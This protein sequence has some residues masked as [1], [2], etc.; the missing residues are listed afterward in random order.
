[1]LR[2]REA[3]INAPS[4]LKTPRVGKTAPTGRAAV[5]LQP[6]VVL[7][8]RRMGRK[9]IGSLKKAAQ[10]VKEKRKTGESAWIYE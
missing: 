7:R 3:T 6:A 1:M 10:E 5:L 4:A 9:G 2:G 8:G